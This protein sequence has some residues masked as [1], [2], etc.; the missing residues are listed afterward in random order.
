MK[1]EVAGLTAGLKAKREDRLRERRGGSQRTAPTDLMLLAAQLG[2]P[3]ATAN[4]AVLQSKVA[5]AESKLSAWTGVSPVRK[6]DPKLVFRSRWANRSEA[7]FQTKEFAN[8]K[9]EIASA[10]GNVQPIL[11]RVMA[12]PS[13]GM[14]EVLSQGDGPA[15]TPVENYEIAYGHRRHQA[16]MELGLPVAAQITRD[17]SDS[18][19]FTAMDRENRERKNLSVWEQGC[20]YRDALDA[21]LFSSVRRLAEA[22]GVDQ[23]DATRYVQLARLPAEVPAAFMSV[24]DIQKRWAKPL[25]DAVEK[26]CAGLIA[27]A[28]DAKSR[29]LD[30]H[31]VF[32][33]L[34]G[35]EAAPVPKKDVITLAGKKA[36]SIHFGTKGGAVIEF[37]PGSLTTAQAA[38]LA[39]LVRDYLA[40]T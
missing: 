37:A 29:Q 4:L 28:K 8:L 13:L 11:V 39:N 15:I 32:D 16:C 38:G 20:M 23:G 3:T 35:R 19:L 31:A 14:S 5:E 36:A 2:S 18:D 24:L 7:E 33:L 21:G 10:G 9:A 6:L 27:R 30:A 1:D 34:I 12:R 26:D 17:L 22:I 40:R 25:S